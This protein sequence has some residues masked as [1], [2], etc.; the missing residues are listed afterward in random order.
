MVLLLKQVF[1]S[2]SQFFGGGNIKFQTKHSFGTCDCISGK[3]PV[4]NL[5]E[6]EFTLLTCTWYLS[7]VRHTSSNWW[8]ES[9][10]KI[11]SQVIRISGIV[12]WRKTF[13]ALVTPVILF[14]N[15]AWHFDP[16]FPYYSSHESRWVYPGA[17]KVFKKYWGSSVPVQQHCT[18]QNS[19]YACSNC[20]HVSVYLH[21]ISVS[22]AVQQSITVL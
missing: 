15:L 22:K 9:K 13:C 11:H 7:W 17:V 3:G 4:W 16:S 10:N 14:I 18:C 19:F 21:E 2:Q 6:T 20:L 1:W 12:L 5:N 8:S